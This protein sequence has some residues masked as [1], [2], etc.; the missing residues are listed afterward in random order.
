M[1]WRETLWVRGWALRNVALLFL[2]KPSIVELN[3]RRCEIVVPLNWRTRRRDI[4]AMY[5][6][7]L[8]MGAD[9]AG[10]LIAFNM[11]GRTRQPVSFL[12]KDLRAEFLKRAEDDVH[13]GCEQGDEIAALIRRT[14]ESGERQETTVN[15]TASVPTKLTEPVARFALTLSLK[16]R[17]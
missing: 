15:V 2:I 6:G 12:F 14:L 8:C 17:G 13:F 5:L 1:S 10:G 3:D 9:V 7:A 11:I 4:R 16:R